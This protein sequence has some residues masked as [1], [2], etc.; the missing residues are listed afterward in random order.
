MR[1]VLMA[2]SLMCVVVDDVGVD[3]VD[4][5]AVDICVNVVFFRVVDDDVVVDAFG[6]GG[7]VIRV[8]VDVFVECGVLFD[9]GVVIDF[10]CPC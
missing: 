10:V 9:V 2:M 1:L 4:G 8:V 3:C 7:N 5:V 6:V